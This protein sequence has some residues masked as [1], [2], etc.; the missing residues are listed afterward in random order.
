MKDI[1][2]Q[3]H[4]GIEY[5]TDADIN[6]TDADK[7]CTDADKNR[8]NADVRI[9]QINVNK[10]FFAESFHEGYNNGPFIPIFQDALKVI[11]CDKAVKPGTKTVLMY[12]LACVD[13]KNN[14]CTQL[15]DIARDLNCSVDT[16]TRAIQQLITMQVLCR[17]NACGVRTQ[18]YGFTDKI[19]NPRLAVKGNMRRLKKSPLPSIRS[20]D[21]R[22]HLL[23]EGMIPVNDNF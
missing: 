16:V 14:I 7:N 4:D 8:T 6:R 9:I 1:D 17:R 3:Q 21:G 13:E 18:M 2:Y 11:A 15:Q 12:L 23:I 10:L 22:K 20:A 5:R 19:I